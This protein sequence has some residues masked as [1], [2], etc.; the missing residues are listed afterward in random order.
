MGKV[1]QKTSQYTQNG[2]K[3][4]DYFVR[5]DNKTGIYLSIN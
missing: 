2:P 3:I 5:K 1:T 4:F